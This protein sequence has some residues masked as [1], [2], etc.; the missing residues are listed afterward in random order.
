M[1]L[2]AYESSKLYKERTKR[3]YDRKILHKGFKSR[4]QVLLYISRLKLFLEKLKLRRSGPFTI[5]D[6]KPF[7]AIKIEDQS[8][9]HKWLVN[10]QILKIYL[11]GE[12]PQHTIVINLE[13]S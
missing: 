2:N 4:Q 9:Y 12:V 3:N 11:G 6:V 5:K 1:R 10:F 8:K 7:G 13:D